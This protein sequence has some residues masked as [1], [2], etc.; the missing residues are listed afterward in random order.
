MSSYLNDNRIT[1]DEFELIVHEITDTM[2]DLITKNIQDKIRDAMN[3]QLRNRRISLHPSDTITVNY[4]LN[5]DRGF[6]D[7]TLAKVRRTCKQPAPRKY[8][9]ISDFWKRREAQ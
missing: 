2:M 5:F 7:A 3:D 8:Q 4:N 6:V 9:L 1:E